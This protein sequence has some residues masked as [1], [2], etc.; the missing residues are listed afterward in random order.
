M[1][2]S[3]ALPA[4]EFTPLLIVL[5]VL[6]LLRGGLAAC[7]DSLSLQAVWRDSLR[8]AFASRHSAFGLHPQQSGARLHHLAALALPVVLWGGPIWA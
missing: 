1:F 6:L 4:W 3:F 2:S 8:I 5:A 7:R